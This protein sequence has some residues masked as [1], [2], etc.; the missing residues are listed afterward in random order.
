[1]P[2]HVF[3]F[4]CPCCGKP[5]EVNVRSGKARAVDFTESKKGKDLDGLVADAKGEGD[6]LTG[7]FDEARTD[8]ARQQDRLDAMFSDA[9]EKAKKDKHKRPPN[10]FD[11]E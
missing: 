5:I 2:K 6:R 11:L 1:M 3:E 7:L 8:H 4:D 9:A 10:P